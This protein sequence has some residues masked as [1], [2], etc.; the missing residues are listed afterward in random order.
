MHTVIDPL[1]EAYLAHADE[2][3]RYATA[4][5][6]PDEAADV[7]TDAMIKVFD[8]RGPELAGD[9]G[10]HLRAYLY[11]AV[12]TR[13]LDHRRARDRR[14][15][16]DT[17]FV[18]RQRT[19]QHG[20]DLDVDVHRAL[21]SLSPQQRTVAFLVYWGDHR[22]ADVAEILGVSEGTVNKQLARA[23]SRLKEVLRDRS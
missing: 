6:G 7:V 1:E 17:A 2:L 4:I 13:S 10:H 18:R 15:R 23:R 12:Y 20:T 3:I 19:D 14:R 11:R 16:R 5:V 21:G 22:I 8:G 9:A